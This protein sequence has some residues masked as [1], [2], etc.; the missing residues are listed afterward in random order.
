MPQ[1]I[2]DPLP[3]PA[4]LARNLAA[5]ARTSPA[6]VRAIAAASPAANLRLVAT[7]ADLPSVLEGIGPSERA[8]CSRRDPA[9]EA[10]RFADRLDPRDAA[11]AILLGFGAGHHV[12]EVSRRYTGTGGVL[13]F[14]PDVPMLRFVLERIDHSTWITPAHVA[15]ITDPSDS[16]AITNAFRGIEP[17]I[18]MG[19]RLMPHAPSL[20]R[21][22]GSAARFGEQLTNVVRAIKT[23][24][25][26]TLVQSETT[27]RNILM[28]LDRYATGDGIAPLSGVAAGRPAI[29]V[30]AGPSLRRNLDQL[31]DP[32]V[33]ERV[34]VIAVQTVLKTMLARGIRPDLV[35]ALDHHEVSRR[36]YE[37]VTA[38]DVE[39][40][41]L[42]VEPKANPAILDAFPGRILCSEDDLAE[43]LLGDLRRH[44]GP[45]TPGATVAHLAYHLA[46][47][48]GCD[49]VILIGQD[50]GFTD[51]QY[52]AAGAAIHEVWSGELSAFRTLE[53]FEWERIVRARHRLHKAVDPAGRP[54][55]TDEQMLTYLVQFERLFEQD[56]GR[57]LT[58]I[59]ATQGGVAKRATTAMTL[60][61]A[62][63]PT[64]AAPPPPDWRELWIARQRSTTDNHAAGQPAGRPPPSIAAVIDRVRRV[65]QDAWKVSTRS[66]AA[67]ALLERILTEQ[68]DQRLV[69]E[70]IG[71]I[72]DIE[73]EVTGLETAYRL[74]QFIN[75]TGALNRYRADRTIELD[76][77]S[78]GALGV[79]AAQTRRDIQNV[80]WIADA[81]E[82]LGSMLEAAL[83][84]LEGGP[85]QLRE[86]PPPAPIAPA[87]R[88]EPNAG[89][90]GVTAT[91]A[92]PPASPVIAAII[93][94]DPDVGG[95][96]TA[97]SLESIIFPAENL[98]ESTLR[99]LSGTTSLSAIYLLAEQPERVR[100]LAGPAPSHLRIEIIPVEPGALSARRRGVGPA[101]AV[102]YSCW[103][104]GLA[105]LSCYDEAFD[106]ALFAR[107]MHERAID[108]AV[109]V[110][111]DWALVDPELVDQVVA[112][113]LE[114]PAQ[115]PLTFCQCPPGLGAACIA[116]SLVLDL[117]RQADRAGPLASIGG[118]LSYFPSNPRSDLIV[119]P[120]CVTL[121][122]KVRDLPVRCV[123]DSE[124]RRKLLLTAL[125]EID[126][127]AAWAGA[128]EIGGAIAAREASILH[129]VPQLVTLE[130]CTGR[131]SSGRRREWA[132]ESHDACERPVLDPALA[133]RIFDQLAD[134]RADIVLTLA[135]AGD[136]MLH[137]SWLDIA[138]DAK[139]AGIATVHLRTELSA[140]DDQIDRLIADAASPNGVI[141]VISI[142]LMAD[143]RDTYSL[144]MGVDAFDR[145]TRN[146]E[147]LLLGR[148]PR[149]AAAGIPT[150]WIVPRLTRCDAVCDQIESF[151]DKWLT[152]C[153]HCVIDPLPRPVR[154]ERIEPLPP[155]ASALWRR[156]RSGL[157]ILCDGSVPHEL[158][159]VQGVSP[160]GSLASASV[161]ELWKRL[162]RARLDAHTAADRQVQRATR[163]APAPAVP[164]TQL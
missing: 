134:A 144:I 112:R 31:A 16:V 116:S 11:A 10:R 15:L 34:V 153:G 13:V 115:R 124:P 81:A 89:M 21:L 22:A 42:V 2:P 105:G 106:P 78:L 90:A 33:R 110:G 8:L 37:G 56:A 155:P 20:P 12:A 72:K 113:H 47:H 127:R 46:R 154:G 48:M 101:R 137:P 92:L 69:N 86:T 157:S 128:P 141:D 91:S 158:D 74:T 94:V 51:G 32:R 58:T 41:T 146:L 161:R 65:R 132:Q 96:G 4:I 55:Y 24:V 120:A 121:A 150:P 68:K 25:M 119:S 83:V 6:A 45:I 122:P 76:N 61:E 93:P 39:G 131:L 104:G 52:Y 100:Q 73:L 75:Q 123:P 130:L 126:A 97:R 40:V 149:S 17:L 138:A 160:A 129:S 36:F 135:G 50:L 35:T 162:H 133:R 57:G 117:A 59:D 23:N 151:Y 109:I 147:R 163:P 71:R 53:M 140:P 125:D 148:R 29:V 164:Q 63:A 18:A 66:R 159:D 26:T 60:R 143:R 43:S 102:A 5:L 103:R 139:A 7:S 88:S 77:A 114:Q 111:A 85:K 30:S 118:V 3:D 82:H 84:A 70:L 62:L 99:R 49:P 9:A 14:E 95:L 64:L 44:H 108:A 54:I 80:T 79:Q 67:A 156:A 136:P 38:P 19:V 28:N 87:P 107:V 152:R 1:P 98:L 142:D 27:L 145:V